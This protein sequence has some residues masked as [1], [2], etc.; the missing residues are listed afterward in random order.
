MDKKNHIKL[1]YEVILGLVKEGSSVLDLGCGDGE[2]LRILSQKKNV[3]GQGI[4]IDEQ[5][6]YKCV[7]KDLDVIHGDID[8]AL[9]DYQDKSF[10]YVIMNES[11]QQ[12]LHLEKVLKESLRV[13]KKVIVGFPNFTYIK[14]RC[15]LFFR[16]RTPV[17]PSLPYKWYE[18]PNLH[19]LSISDFILFCEEKDVKIE[20]SIFLGVKDKVNLLPNLFANTAIFM[21]SK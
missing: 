1:D 15:Q 19:F 7:E 5:A 11:L 9:A 3:T 6:I 20:K 21:I 13:G 17:T 10:D 2:L 14:S 18:T 4:E 12:V 8:T 16:G